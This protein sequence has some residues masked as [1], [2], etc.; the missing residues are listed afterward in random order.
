MIRK[1][2]YDNDA[3]CFFSRNNTLGDIITESILP[4][5]FMLVSSIV[6]NLEEGK[7]SFSYSRD[8]IL[9]LAGKS[10]KFYEKF[11][12]VP[13]SFRLDIMKLDE[14]SARQKFGDLLVEHMSMTEIGDE[15][16]PMH[17]TIWINSNDKANDTYDEGF[18]NLLKHELGHVWTFVL[19][20][21]DN[22]F[23]CGQ[24]PYSS[25]K[26]LDPSKFTHYQ[27]DVWLHLYNGML[28]FL[29]NDFNYILGKGDKE[30]SDFELPAHIDNIIEILVADF[31]ELD[32]KSPE[33]YLRSIWMK[34]SPAH[35]KTFEPMNLL[36][37]FRE[38][39]FYD[40][41]SSIEAVKNPIRRLFL[42]FAFGSQEQI[43]YLREACEEEFGK[44]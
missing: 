3:T 10:W 43:D 41:Y 23:T 1:L 18:K 22:S 16:D 29:E 35:F 17:E 6:K 27:K 42:V 40:G 34:L 5:P 14:A 12:E 8:D 28:N 31:L 37:H 24:G 25:R 2:A 13:S 32:L 19:G 38:G 20:G 39:L 21:M 7:T 11:R 30:T 33:A 4:S 44:L 36:T 26:K 15:A 9:T